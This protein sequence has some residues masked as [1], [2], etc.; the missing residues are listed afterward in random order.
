MRLLVVVLCLG[1]LFVPGQ[2]QSAAGLIRIFSLQ[3]GQAEISHGTPSNVGDITL[4]GTSLRARNNKTIGYSTM[5]CIAFGKTL[6]GAISQCTATYRLPLGK[7]VVTG[8]RKR[9]DFYVLAV[10]GGTGIYSRASGTLVA[11]TTALNPRRER[12]LFS[13]ES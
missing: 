9:R 1:L 7:I 10:T 13:L 8:T 4:I 2:A 12:L 11:S 6:P 3:T 5:T